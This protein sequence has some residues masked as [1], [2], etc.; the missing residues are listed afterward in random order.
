MDFTLPH[1]RG[2][3]LP[4]PTA[5]RATLDKNNHE[6]PVNSLAWSCDGHHLATG[7]EDKTVKIWQF[8][9]GAVPPFS[10][11]KTDGS[12]ILQSADPRDL[13]AQDSPATTSTAPITALAFSPRHPD[14]LAVASHVEG[15]NPA[16]HGVEGGLHGVHVVHGSGSRSGRD[17][18]RSGEEKMQ[19]VPMQRPRVTIWNIKTRRP[20]ST[21]L[22][23]HNPVSMT[24]H[25]SAYQLLIV[26]MDKT[27]VDYGVFC[28]QKE[29]SI[30]AEAINE[31]YGSPLDREVQPTDTID[32]ASNFLKDDT[33]IDAA[34]R[35]KRKEDVESRLAHQRR[36]ET[37]GDEGW[38]I[39]RDVELVLKERSE[40]MRGRGF[41]G[42]VS[43]LNGACFSPCGTRLYTGNHDGTVHL[44]HYPTAPN[45]GPSTQ[46]AGSPMAVEADP[47]S[48]SEST[49][50]AR[51]E[52]ENE[53][54]VQ[55]DM[56]TSGEVVQRANMASESAEAISTP[57]E[58]HN[59]KA[60]DGGVIP[61]SPVLP[62]QAAEVTKMPLVWLKCIETNQGCV[63]CIE[64]DPR[65]RF[66]VTGGSE[67]LVAV[68]TLA[69]GVP[70][71]TFSTYT[72]EIKYVKLS[73]NGEVLVI[74]G[75]DRVELVNVI[76]GD[77]RRIEVD[78]RVQ[79]VQWS[80]ARLVLTW[81]S[82]K[83]GETS[84]KW[85]SLQM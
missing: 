21:I 12:T 28:W 45:A 5:P 2:L 20:I 39:R 43:E 82:V 44:W 60:E 30:T 71:T 70:F 57:P 55:G 67:G 78:G 80:P 8:K 76:D 81:V 13:S 42:G 50:I 46:S 56:D 72:E 77:V 36:V 18:A 64:M 75:S 62:D 51:V 52:A 37:E 41:D 47:P 59:Q 35:R 11:V 1:V 14:I 68:C 65:R 7:G 53:E 32:P 40:E 15:W 33:A 61:R 17:A 10:L 27:A 38:T 29:T 25:P 23:S 6:G 63:N 58:G 49:Q 24:F 48:V 3:K 83:P 34:E 79:A 54:T 16:A 73:W 9:H 31:T 26:C 4:R 84:A 66:F 22:L 19:K 85:Y 74:A 69:D